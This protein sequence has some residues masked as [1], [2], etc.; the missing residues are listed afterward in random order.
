[1]SDPN[2]WMTLMAPEKP[3]SHNRKWTNREHEELR[4]LVRRHYEANGAT[5]PMS[6][7]DYQR[8]A[9]ALKRTT[10]AVQYKCSTMGLT[11]RQFAKQQEEPEPTQA[12]G[13][14][15]SM[16]LPDAWITRADRITDRLNEEGRYLA[17]GTM[18]RATVLRLAL[19][20]GLDSLGAQVNE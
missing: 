12:H 6:I 13:T 2:K 17:F 16:R 19:Q 1:M 7:A 10:K 3:A 14:P 18:T 9:Q 20:R 5:V 11:S 8:I 15:T 4:R